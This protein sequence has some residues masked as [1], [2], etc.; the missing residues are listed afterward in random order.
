MAIVNELTKIFERD[1]D[2]LKNEIQAFELEE[3]IWRTAGRLPNSAG[4]L[5]LHLV[6]NLNTFIGNNIGKYDY[7][8]KRELEFSVKDVPRQKLLE[9]VENVKN[10]VTASLSRIDDDTLETMEI[11]HR[12]A[13]EMTNT[14]LLVHLATHLSYHLGQINYLRRMLES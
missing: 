11:T 6:G 9:Q 14:F 13:N 1:L 2:R 8:R 5:C 10:I 4:N 3:N 12:L 7:V